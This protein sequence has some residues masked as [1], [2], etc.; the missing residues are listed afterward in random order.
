MKELLQLRMQGVKI[1]EADSW[2]EKINGTLT[3]HIFSKRANSTREP[4]QD[5]NL[6]DTWWMQRVENI[7]LWLSTDTDP[8]I[9][10]MT[11]TVSSKTGKIPGLDLQMPEQVNYTLNWNLSK[12]NEDLGVIKNP[13]GESLITPSP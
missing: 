12:F 4:L 1:E 2:L 11:V 8:R 7:S 13:S 9:M 5:L 10:R 6:Y 3:R